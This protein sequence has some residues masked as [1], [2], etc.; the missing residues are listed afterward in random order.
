MPVIDE[1]GIPREIEGVSEKQIAYAQNLRNSY[2]ASNEK[3]LRKVSDNLAE[4]YANLEE[5]TR[6]AIEY[7]YDANNLPRCLF[8]ER[9]KSYIV[10]TSRSASEIIDTLLDD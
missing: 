8:D 3:D 2:I 7:G 5:M 4:F 10:L 6:K 9:I 1:L